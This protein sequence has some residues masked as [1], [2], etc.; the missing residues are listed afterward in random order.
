MGYDIILFG[1]TAAGILTVAIYS[2][3]V[4]HSRVYPIG[5]VRRTPSRSVAEDR[6]I[7]IYI[8][9]SGEPC[10]LATDFENNVE[11]LRNAEI[12]QDLGVSEETVAQYRRQ[13]VKLKTGVG[14]TFQ[15]FSVHGGGTAWRQHFMPRWYS[16]QFD[17]SPQKQDPTLEK[18]VAEQGQALRALE[19]R[20]RELEVQSVQSVLEPQESDAPQ[21]PQ[22]RTIH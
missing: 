14:K 11:G 10:G 8:D 21:A 18:K 7:T 3:K 6:P 19:Q 15:A 22:P 16:V 13:S 5:I 4:A 2:Y 17:L 1:L 20:I 9:E 12:A